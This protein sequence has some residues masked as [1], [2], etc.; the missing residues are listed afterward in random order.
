MSIRAISFGGGQ[1]STAL[2]ILAARR[3][4]DFPLFIFANV[5]DDSEHPATLQ[6]FAEYAQPFAAEHGIELAEVDWVG[7]RGPRAGEHRTLYGDLTRSDSTSIDIPVHMTGGGPSN[8]KCTGRYKIEVVARELARR[9]ATEDD[10]AIV[11]M[12]ISLDEIERANDRSPIPHER[13][14]YPL[15]ELGLR[16]TDCQRIIRSAG[17]P[18]PRKSA[19]WF[20]P[21]K[22]PAEWLDMRRDEPELFAKA[23]DLEAQLIARRTSMRDRNGK[24]RDAAYLTSLGKPLAEA[25]PDGVDVLPLGDGDG[26]CDSGWCMT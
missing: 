12:G 26:A 23:C 9:G 15:L 22:K 1:Q 11:G 5:G 16:R 19:C 14:T 24:L 6:Y 8:R 17:L 21:M 10:P 25:I 20:C 2:L 7:Q 3:E 13:V 4:I 18:I